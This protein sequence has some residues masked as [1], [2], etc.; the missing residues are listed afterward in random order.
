MNV[1]TKSIRKLV[2]WCPCAKVPD[3]GYRIARE[4]FEAHDQSGSE[5]ARILPTALSKFSRLRTYNLLVDTGFSLAYGLLL[6]RIGVNTGAFLTGLI[7]CLAIC[8]S[9]WK[10]QM[11]RYDTLEKNPVVDY[12]DKQKFTWILTVIIPIIIFLAYTDR[13][14]NMPLL[15]SFGAGAVASMWLS[16]FQIIYWEYKNH[17]KIYINRR[18]GKW[19]TSY[20]IREK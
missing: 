20:L 6:A 2:G 7:I 9:K 14:L 19:K 5:K 18:C 10:K 12:S 4:N 11:Q 15:F 17:K 1:F 3:S 13:F 8:I 16:Y